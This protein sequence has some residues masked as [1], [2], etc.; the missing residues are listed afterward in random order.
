MKLE[1]H[2]KL[3][4][5]SEKTFLAHL[6]EAKRWVAV[7]GATEPEASAVIAEYT[8]NQIGLTANSE[9]ATYKSALSDQER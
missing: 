3:C 1:P 4:L 7:S 8:L 2:T 6:A 5:A 9:K